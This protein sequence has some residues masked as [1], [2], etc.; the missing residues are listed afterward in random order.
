MTGSYNAG[1]GGLT[2]IVTRPLIL[3]PAVAATAVSITA[4][5]YRCFWYKSTN[6]NSN[7]NNNN[8]LSPQAKTDA[9]TTTTI[10]P[11]S[12]SA[13]IV[14]PPLRHVTP[15]PGER[16]RIVYLTGIDKQTSEGDLIELFSG[17]AGGRQ[18]R[19]QQPPPHPPIEIDASELSF[20]KVGGRAWALYGSAEDAGRAVAALHGKN[21][22]GCILCARLERGVEKNG[23]RIT[24]KTTH[25]AIVRGI[26]RRRGTPKK[27]QATGGNNNNVNETNGNHNKP[28][29]KARPNNKAN[30]NGDD[31]SK[32]S[33]HRASTDSV[34]TYS[35]N[36]ILIGEMEYPFPSGIYSTKL[37]QGMAA[38]IVSNDDEENQQKEYHHQQRQRRRRGQD[39]KLLRLLSDVSILGCGSAQRYAKEVSEVFSMVDALERGIKLAFGL[40]SVDLRKPVVCYCLGDGKY[41][42]GAAALK[43]FLPKHDESDW[44]FIA[45]DPLLPK[46]GGASVDDPGGGD[47]TPA[48]STTTTTTDVAAMSTFHDRIELFSGFSQDYSIEHAPSNAPS[49]S[50]ANVN[51]S[52]N[53]NANKG[54]NASNGGS[55]TKISGVLSIA[56]A[57]HSHAPLEEFWER[58]PTPKLCVAMPCCAQFSELPKET[59]IC[60]YDNY[61]IYSPKRRIKIFAST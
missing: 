25:T 24:D 6:D 58:M 18:Q 43:L 17:G 48:S 52:V 14:K 55:P 29:K 31:Y 15:G 10:N 12:S 44:K 46:H 53:D 3:L 5:V 47:P 21:V 38:S 13:S 26:Q 28:K 61:E 50:N 49:C 7:S 20:S 37:I 34:V 2:T 40:S 33:A 59:P 11:S 22:R 16:P 51:A 4:M 32:E 45:I 9:T 1:A 36:S 57:C 56:I 27:K 35:H 39:E 42:I 60:E 23:T 8:P 41:P 54:D 19:Q 30:N